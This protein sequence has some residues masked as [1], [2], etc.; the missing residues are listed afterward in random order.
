VLEAVEAM[1]ANDA[2]DL[3]GEATGSDHRLEAIAERA[4]RVEEREA[5]RLAKLNDE[6]DEVPAPSEAAVVQ[7]DEETDLSEHDWLVE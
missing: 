2:E 4:R 1:M 5:K 3:E 7:A 6:A